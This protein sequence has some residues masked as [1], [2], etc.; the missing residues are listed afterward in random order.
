MMIYDTLNFQLIS[1]I[2][3]LKEA[4]KEEV[5][6]WD[7]QKPTPHNFFGDRVVPFLIEVLNGEKDEIIT[8]LFAF[9]DEMA[10]AQDTKIQE[11]LA[12]SVLE[13]LGDD[14]KLLEKAYP[15]M[16]CDVKKMSRE[17]DVFWRRK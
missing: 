7:G 9:F 2:P 8:K 5:N 3:E 13:K 12:F 4:Y 16:S 10:S 11:V 6:W 15:F 14:R 1:K 17:T